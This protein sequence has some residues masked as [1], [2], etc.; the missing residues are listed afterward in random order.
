MRELRGKSR[1]K[2]RDESREE[3][4]EEVREERG[5]AKKGRDQNMDQVTGRM[6]SPNSTSSHF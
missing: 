1:C 3:V 6:A 2:F 4:R 5:Y